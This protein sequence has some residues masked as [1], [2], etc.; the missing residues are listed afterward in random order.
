MLPKMF[1]RA[2]ALIV[3]RSLKAGRAGK[4]KRA[5]EDPEPIVIEMVGELRVPTAEFGG[6]EVMV[7]RKAG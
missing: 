7:I 3:D 6:T 4:V 1:L 2:T 5:A